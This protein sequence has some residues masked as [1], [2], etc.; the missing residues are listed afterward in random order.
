MPNRP[1]IFA[2]FLTTVVT[3]SLAPSYAQTELTAPGGPPVLTPPPAS[4]SILTLAVGESR[5]LRFPVVS[6]AAIGNPTVADIAIL[7]RSEVL[8]NAKAAG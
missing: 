7:S 6:R 4:L 3:L 2:A 5:I 1:I 8:L